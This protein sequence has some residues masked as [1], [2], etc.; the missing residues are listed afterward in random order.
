MRDLL[1][2]IVLVLSALMAPARADVLVADGSVPLQ[3]VIDGALD[4][5]IV[6]VKASVEESNNIIDVTAR[7]LAL[8]G[9]GSPPHLGRLLIRDLPAGGQVT[10]GNL[11]VGAVG[12]VGGTALAGSIEV[13]NCDGA[14]TIEACSV[15]SPNQPAGGWGQSSPGMPGLLV[16]DSAAVTVLRNR[17]LGGNGAPEQP[18][19]TIPGYAPGSRGGDGLRAVTSTVTLHAC[20]L[21]GGS[22]GVKGT[23]SC[24]FNSEPG[25]S[26]LFVQD[27][28]V[29][30]AASAATGGDMNLSGGHSSAPGSG[31]T[32]LTPGSTATLRGTTVM[33]GLGPPDVPDVVDL[34][35]TLLTY[36]EPPRTVAVSSPLR[37]LQSGQLLIDGQ[38]GDLTALFLAFSGGALPSTGKQGVWALGNPNFGPVL[39]AVN[40]FGEWTIPFTAGN[41]TP[42]FLQGQVFLLQLV[43][44]TPGG[45]VLLEGNTTY[46]LVDASIP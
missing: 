22:G 24:F 46:T 18:S 16:V 44:R 28:T 21:T 8:V 15:T 17:L 33:A 35:G 4:G 19:C 42:S 45:Q 37:E 20:E 32:L 23:F 1:V 5:D 34:G 43:V 13:T 25:G 30:A 38:A 10:V 40:P 7:S 2:P 36:P 12:P 6:L 29:H 9:D 27:A 31:L 41:L 11:V 14:V 39:L 3:D 26:G